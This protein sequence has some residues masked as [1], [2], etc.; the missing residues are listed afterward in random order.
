[1]PGGTDT[2]ASFAFE[3]EDHTLG[4]ALRYMIMKNPDVEFCGYSIPHPSEAV[5]NLR[6]QTWDGVN[7]MEVLRKGLDDLSDMCDAVEE[8]F[9]TARDEF[10]EAN[11]D[12][13]SKR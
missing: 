1:L 4:N 2:A 11:P 7:V 10:N 9:T 6:I 3:K 13:V 12:R 5:M 8:K